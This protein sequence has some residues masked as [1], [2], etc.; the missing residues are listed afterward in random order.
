MSHDFRIVTLP[1][2]LITGILMMGCTVITTI[3]SSSPGSPS[4][5]TLT[6]PGA[7]TDLTNQASPQAAI[8]RN[9][10][11]IT[12]LGPGKPGILL[13]KIAGGFSAPMM[14]AAIPDGSGRTVIVD[15]IGLVKLMTP[16]NKISDVPFMDLRERMVPL[17]TGY[18]ERGLL[19]LAF[20]PDFRNNGRV[21]VYYSAP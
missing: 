12:P 7:G 16:D 1:F 19:S 18:D 20:H 15:Q 2:L 3:P 8:F 5:T 10:A 17:D 11:S 4:V 9:G 13:R 6:V 14:M 21:F